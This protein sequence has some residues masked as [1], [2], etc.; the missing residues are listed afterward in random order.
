[1]FEKGHQ[2]KHRDRF[3]LGPDATGYEWRFE[4][5]VN[6]ESTTESKIDTESNMA[7]MNDL[8]NANMQKALESFSKEKE[9]L[10]QR[11]FQEKTAQENLKS[12]RDLLQ[13]ELKTKREEFEAKQKLENEEFEKRLFD[14]KE[15]SEQQRK[16]LEEKLEQERK[17]LDQK[18]SDLEAEMASKIAESEAKMAQTLKD[19]EA[20]MTALQ[21]EKDKMEE[22]L[23]SERETF[24]EQLSKLE[25]NNQESESSHLQKLKHLKE[26]FGERLL[27]SQSDFEASVQ[28]EKDE[29]EKEKQKLAKEL[30]QKEAKIAQLNAQ[31]QGVEDNNAKKLKAD[32][33]KKCNDELKCTICDELFIRPMALNC[34]HVFCQFC[35]TQWESRAKTKKDFTCPNCRVLITVQ[36]RSMHIENLISA[37]YRDVDE[38]LSKEREDL[39]YER[40]LEIEKALKADPK[41]ARIGQNI[42][43]WA[44]NVPSRTAAPATATTSGA[45]NANA[46]GPNG[47]PA[48][49]VTYGLP[50]RAQGTNGP[51]APINH[52]PVRA[53]VGP[54]PALVD[55]TGPQGPVVTRPFG[56]QPGSRGPINPRHTGPQRSTGPQR[57]VGTQPGPRTPI[58][59]RP[60]GPPNALGPRII[61]PARPPN[62]VGPRII[63]PTGPQRPVGP[64]PVGPLALSGPQRPVV[65]QGQYVPAFCYTDLQGVRQQVLVLR[66]PTTTTTATAATAVRA[67]ASTSTITSGTQPAGARYLNINGTLHKINE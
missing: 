50:V 65:P 7:A 42:R 37:I 39:I 9:T 66:P 46:Q 53:Q 18:Q 25:E 36:S 29:R 55:L 31:L 41:M 47:P 48:L 38:T 28:K 20:S 34:G 44:Q 12:E 23:N 22:K 33:L 61:R 13:Q 45:R 6:N 67:T 49:M 8:I 52:G 19:R 58:I 1:M 24:R 26:D 10:E 3:S 15:V 57:P 62:A 56:P 43:Q 51:R 11:V 59:L 14:T 30:D 35:V 54:R 21:K 32:L 16:E 63:R 40:K 2:L 27:K 64:R 17:E 5:W 60:T 4:E